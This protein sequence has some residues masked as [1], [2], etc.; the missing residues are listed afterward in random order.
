MLQPQVFAVGLFVARKSWFP[1]SS[2]SLIILLHNKFICL[3]SDVFSFTFKS[4]SESMCVTIIIT[5]IF[6]FMF[7]LIMSLFESSK[8]VL[9]N[10]LSYFIHDYKNIV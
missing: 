7:I 1:K 8:S 4:V 5:I 2:Q 9:Y 10:F 3:N 6:Y